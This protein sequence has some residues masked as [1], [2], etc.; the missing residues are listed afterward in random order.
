MS[1][2]INIW[3]DDVWSDHVLA[4]HFCRPTARNFPREGVST[5]V[6]K[7]VAT[8]VRVHIEKDGMQLG[9]LFLIRYA[10]GVVYN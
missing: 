1:C 7:R 10:Q 5:S 8:G 9:Q 6:S 4:D 2:D 3:P